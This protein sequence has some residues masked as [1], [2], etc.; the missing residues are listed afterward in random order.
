MGNATWWP[1]ISI[2]R[3]WWIFSR[4]SSP[5]APGS[6]A[7]AS[8]IA[9][10][11]GIFIFPTRNVYQPVVEMFTKRLTNQTT[12]Q[13]RNEPTNE[14][15]DQGATEG[16]HNQPL[17]PIISSS[18]EV[19][20]LFAMPPVFHLSERPLSRQPRQLHH[21]SCTSCTFGS[22]RCPKLLT[23]WESLTLGCS[24]RVMPP[25]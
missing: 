12:N 1:S 18:A 3:S 8:T 22:P 13:P 15:K 5:Q 21:G 4:T 9:G 6:L 16:P 24:H 7:D 2:T 14:P 23:L 19:C 11:L 10:S 25:K 20:N 17:G